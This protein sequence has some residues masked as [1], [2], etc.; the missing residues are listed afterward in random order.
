V[1]EG[2]IID[3]CDGLNVWRKAMITSVF[4]G[5]NEESMVEVKFIVKGEEFREKVEAESNRLAPYA[6]F[7]KGRYLLNFLPSLPL[8]EIAEFPLQ[9]LLPK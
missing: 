9:R 8:P 7:T 5:D 1:R 6:F 3:F 2:I 4:G